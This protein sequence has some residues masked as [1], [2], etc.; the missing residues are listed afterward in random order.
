MQ[1]HLSKE[2]WGREIVLAGS[3]K[4]T[5]TEAHFLT[6][7]AQHWIQDCRITGEVRRTGNGVSGSCYAQVKTCSFLN[8]ALRHWKAFSKCQK[9]CSHSSS[10]QL[11][12]PMAHFPSLD[13]PSLS[14]PGPGWGW[15]TYRRKITYIFPNI[16]WLPTLLPAALHKPLSK[17]CPMGH[18]GHGFVATMY[19]ETK[20]YSADVLY[21]G[22]LPHSP[23]S[24]I[25]YRH[26]I[27]ALNA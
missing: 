2:L 11:V 1:K 22:L 8:F 10:F 16:L 25:C 6:G 3:R 13:H 5:V 19:S 7:R 15:P 24:W 4:A 14:S 12:I 21:V 26:L 20:R 27:W 23:P 18:L 9:K 17:Y